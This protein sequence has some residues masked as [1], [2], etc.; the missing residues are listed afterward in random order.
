MEERVTSDTP[1]KDK[2]E[3]IEGLAESVIIIYNDKSGKIGKIEIPRYIL[4]FTERFIQSLN[5][6]EKVKSTEFYQAFIEEFNIK[7]TISNRHLNI[8]KDTLKSVGLDDI[9]ISH[10]IEDLMKNR[11]FGL[12]TYKEFIGSRKV[13]TAKYFQCW[14]TL[15]YFKE[16][17]KILYNSRGSV[18]R[19][20]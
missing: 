19:I 9:R 16:K 20:I 2:I 15:R 14:G 6:G 5:V 13:D 17:G 12:M 11:E 10:I 1:G 4:D 8:F 18:T 7:S 3:A